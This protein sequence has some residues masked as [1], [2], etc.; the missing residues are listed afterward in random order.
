MHGGQGGLGWRSLGL[1][2]ACPTKEN[3]PGKAF[4]NVA[5]TPGMVQKSILSTLKRRDCMPTFFESPASGG[6]KGKAA[7][8]GHPINCHIG[9]DCF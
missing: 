1:Y 4:D 3:M 8:M 5:V 2:D 9:T 6:Q 7:R